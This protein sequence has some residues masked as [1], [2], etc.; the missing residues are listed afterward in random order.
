MLIFEFH[1]KSQTYSVRL[2]HQLT[3]EILAHG[4][5]TEDS[6]DADGYTALEEKN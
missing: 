3:F 1:S 4:L 6:N 2:Y 5:E